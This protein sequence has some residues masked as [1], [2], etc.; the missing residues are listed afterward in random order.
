MIADF[1]DRWPALF[2]ESGVSTS[3]HLYAGVRRTNSNEFL[4]DFLWHGNKGLQHFNYYL[5]IT[6]HACLSDL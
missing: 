5:V 6:P 3:V 4:V 1:K 2:Q